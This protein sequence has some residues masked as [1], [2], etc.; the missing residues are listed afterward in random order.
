MSPIAHL[1]LTAMVVQL[2]FELRYT[3]FGLTN[4]QWTFVALVLAGIPLLVQ[5]RKEL[6]SD[7]LLRAVAVFILMQWLAVL[8]AP[9]FQVNASKAAARLTAGLLL[10]AIAKCLGVASRFRTWAL[11]AGAAAGYALVDYAGYGWPWLFRTEEFYLGQ[12]RR[13][14]GSFEY[15][16]IA[17]AYFAVSLPIIWWSGLQSKLRTALAF[18]I[19]CA[20]ILTF[21]NGALLAIPL[22]ALIALRKAALPLLAIGI[23]AY[24]VMAP[25]NPYLAER[26]YKPGLRNP[27]AVKYAPDWNQFQQKPGVP[28]AAPIHIQNTGI[29]TL[30]SHG[31]RRAAVAYRWWNIETEHFLDATPIITPL[32]EDIH[33]GEGANVLVAFQTPDKPG[34]YLLVIELFRRN[35]DWFSRIGV[36][37]ALIKTE[38][39][40]GANRIT[41]N[42]DMN[43]F[44]SRGRNTQTLTAAVSRT[45]LWAAALNMFRDHP[46]GIGPD[47]YRLMYGKYLGAA[48]WDTNVHSNNLYL[49]ILTGS[50]FLGLA[51]FLIAIGT[52]LWKAD[53]ASMAAAIFLLHGTVDV[54]LMTTP[55]YFAFWL[56]FAT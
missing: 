2:P 48:A 21:S 42:T 30:Q 35:F 54:F 20:T 45:R 52:R 41:G 49:E 1:L 28:D 47:N 6:M 46:F 7:R 24:V 38:I 29:A 14:S 31:R 44:Y 50:G 27:I 15:P 43:A 56:L 13:L 53:V 22:A 33:S 8:V 12:I 39:R 17:A 34:T 4:L 37:P 51:A 18:V 10:I 9:Q 40:S 5:N 19:W 55:I 25:V 3:L 16:N 11:A 23:A 26:L 32:T 36:V